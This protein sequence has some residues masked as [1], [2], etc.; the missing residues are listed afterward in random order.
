LVSEQCEME[1]F[2][3]KVQML[4]LLLLPCGILGS[5]VRQMMIKSCI[6]VLIVAELPDGCGS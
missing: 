1:V 4:L 6:A 5:R 2:S 3:I